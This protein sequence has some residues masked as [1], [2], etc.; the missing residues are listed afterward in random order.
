MG[1]T[2]G[3][4]ARTAWRRAGGTGEPGAGAD[5]Q[6]VDRGGR[7]L[8]LARLSRVMSA[9]PRRAREGPVGEDQDRALVA[10]AGDGEAAGAVGLDELLAGDEG[11]LGRSGRSRRGD[12]GLRLGGAAASALA[13]SGSE[14]WGR[15]LR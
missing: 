6:D 13:G 4:Q 7:G 14:E 8:G 1:S 2:T 9:G 10:H 15:M 12:L 3:P 11:G 5:E